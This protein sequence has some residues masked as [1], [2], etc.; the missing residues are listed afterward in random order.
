MLDKFF[1]E[2]TTKTQSG[3]LLTGFNSTIPSGLKEGE[4]VNLSKEVAAMEAYS[5]IAEKYAALQNRK[6]QALLKLNAIKIKHKETSV[7][8]K[9]KQSEM[10]IKHVQNLSLANVSRLQL[11]GEIEGFKQPLDSSSALIEL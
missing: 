11:E 10:G 7:G 3:E 1:P 9:L 5:S 4:I 6:E 2:L 8:N